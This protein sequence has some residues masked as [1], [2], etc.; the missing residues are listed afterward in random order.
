M[1]LDELFSTNIR[2]WSLKKQEIY[3]N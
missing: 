3:R 1:Q 2:A